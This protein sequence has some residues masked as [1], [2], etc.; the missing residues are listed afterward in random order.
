[1]IRALL[2][3]LGLALSAAGCSTSSVTQYGASDQP[4]VA[5]VARVACVKM[6]GSRLIRRG[7]C[8]LPGNSYSRAAL[9][10]TGAL[11][12]AGALARLDPGIR[13][14]SH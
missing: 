8:Y 3:G 12:T 6:T 1:M 5:R 9:E 4:R 7:D 13:S 14:R 2:L 10:S 11:T